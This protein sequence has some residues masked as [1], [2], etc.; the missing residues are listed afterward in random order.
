MPVVVSQEQMLLGAEKG[1]IMADMLGS[2]WSRGTIFLILQDFA[3]IFSL[4]PGAL[5]ICI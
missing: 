4:K 1:D 3:R 5:S 2:M